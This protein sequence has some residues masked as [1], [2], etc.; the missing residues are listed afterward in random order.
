MQ[1]QG[2]HMGSVLRC[3]H[4]ASY[5][6]KDMSLHYVTVSIIKQVIMLRTQD[7]DSENQV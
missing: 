1:R 5:E 6:N 3:V 7:S 4:V 2:S